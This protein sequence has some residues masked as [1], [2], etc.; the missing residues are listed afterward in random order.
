ML[1]MQKIFKYSA[2]YV[3]KSGRFLYASFYCISSNCSG[4]D[5]NENEAIST[6]RYLKV[7]GSYM[8]ASTV[9]AAIFLVLIIM[10]EVISG[11]RFLKV[12]GSYMWVSTV[13]SIQYDILFIFSAAHQRMSF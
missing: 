1:Y 10:N 7:E 6:C 3:L 13:Y 11:F 2:T 8:L 4:F 5:Y 12:E 9:L